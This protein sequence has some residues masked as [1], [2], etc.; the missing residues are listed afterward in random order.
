MAA[1]KLQISSV[2]TA[3]TRVD[4]EH[5]AECAGC[6]LIGSTYGE[7]LAFKANR[8]DRAFAHFEFA[9]P[10]ESV[11]AAD[12]IT[13]YR[14]RA[15]LMVSETGKIGLFAKDGDHIVVDIPS[16]RVLALSLSRAAQ[17]LRKLVAADPAASSIRAVDLREVRSSGDPLV[18]ATLVVDRALAPP[19]DQL[20]ALSD[21]IRAADSIFAGIA[22]NFR[23]A[24]APQVLGDQTT[25][26]GGVSQAPDTH[27]RST[28]LATFGAFVQAHRAQ[29]ARVHDEVI[30]ALELGKGPK[31][32]LDLYGGAGAIALALAANGADVELVESF[33]PAVERAR[34]AARNQNVVL[35]A[36]TSDVSRALRDFVQKKRQYHA[37]VA[38]PPRR[39]MSA[40]ARERLAE[41]APDRIA[42]VSCDPETLA[43]DLDHFSRLGYA[44]KRSRP[45]DM[46]PLTEEV[47]TVA[48]LIR[49]EPPAVSVLFESEE[50]LA[51]AK[52][53]HEPT[54]ALQK[55]VRRISGSENAIAI[56]SFD[57][58]TSGVAIFVKRV[59]RL[60]SWTNALRADN[61]L[62]SFLIVCRGIA[63]EKGVISRGNK[64]QS[65]VSSTRYRR[66]AIV[67]GHSLVRANASH[68]A[69][70]DSAD[71]GV[72]KH[73]AEIGHPPVGDPRFGD[74]RTNRF[75]EEKH[76][77]D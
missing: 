26:L 1:S 7:Q 74:A 72:C 10:I 62:I 8:V 61:A 59:Q 71:V 41:L 37:A 20:R 17:T 57:R 77:L 73:L 33:G 64:K 30:A 13:D 66:L 18:L 23:A 70:R 67:G 4:C 75:F 36:T 35:H 16:C 32:V 31:R 52:E 27:G 6:P 28:H 50:I 56:T 76:A 22:V 51:V 29:A 54:S 15:K 60:E 42:Y 25:P 63:R 43:R 2:I 14:S 21:R 69:L 11:A 38:N 12:A 44:T 39:G 68:V 58:A 24:N 65:R 5:A 49:A 45:V 34:Q 3:E 47:E 46:I 53:A 9:A 40:E 55:R 19:L 48:T